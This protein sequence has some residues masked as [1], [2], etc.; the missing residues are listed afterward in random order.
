MSIVDT[1]AAKSR[2]DHQPPLVQLLGDASK[3][4][5]YQTHFAKIKV[6]GSK[7][8]NFQFFEEENLLF[9]YGLS[10]IGL[11]EMMRIH[12]YTPRV[13]RAFYSNLRIET[14][15]LIDSVKGTSIIIPLEALA[16]T[17]GL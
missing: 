5:R 13:I 3:V 17:L 11:T 10:N 9:F 4:K 16:E 15:C 12:E 14:N 7:Y 1:A 2:L 8:V 6:L